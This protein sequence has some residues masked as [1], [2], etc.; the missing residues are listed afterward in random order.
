MENARE[1]RGD[2]RFSLACARIALV[3]MNRVSGMRIVCGADWILY[4]FGKSTTHATLSPGVELDS[5]MR[6]RSVYEEARRIVPQ[7]C[8]AISRTELQTVNTKLETVET[9]N[10]RM[11]TEL[12]HTRTELQTVNAQNE[13]LETEVIDLKR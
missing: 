11:Q 9:Q 7:C 4:F 3:R 8:Y 12:M 13:R 10:T 2:V 1:Q 5:S 6:K